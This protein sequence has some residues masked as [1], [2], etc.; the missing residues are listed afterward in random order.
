MIILG[1]TCLKKNQTLN[2]KTKVLLATFILGMFVITK[3]YSGLLMSNLTKPQTLK[4]LDTIEDVYKSDSEIM[5]FLDTGAHNH[6]VY[7]SDPMLK[8]IL[9]KYRNQKNT[10]IPDTG[11]Y[12][13]IAFN[14][15]TV[16]FSTRNAMQYE[17][18]T[19]YTTLSG[20]SSAYI[21]KQHIQGSGEAFVIQ[22]GSPLEDEMSKQ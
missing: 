8:K 4:K 10:H 2:K 13:H 5:F 9:E 15:K 11:D 20:Q 17:I 12:S 18:K 21:G 19:K 16:T 7:S 3:G 1:Q 6:F 14:E 22:K